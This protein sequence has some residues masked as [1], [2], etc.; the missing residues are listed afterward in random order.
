MDIV[1]VGP[2]RAGGALGIAASEAGHR[3]V[4]VAGRDPHRTEALAERLGAAPRRLDAPLGPA[5]LLVLAVRDDA[6]RPVAAAVDASGIPA[7]VHLSGARPVVDLEP[8]ADRGVAV[9]V[10]H[11]LQTLPDPET[12]AA[13]LA[14]AWA[15]IT[16]VD[17]LADVLEGLARD[18]GMRPFHLADDHRVL[19]HAGAAAAA[20]AVVA[21]LAVAARLFARAEVPFVAARPLVETVVANAFD[22]GPARALTGPVARGDV[23]TVRAQLAA[24][25]EGAPETVPAFAALVEAVAVVAG[26]SP[27]EFR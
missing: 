11:P 15:A 7:A 21:A 13:A 1:I 10:F 22:L 27:E 23:A 9:G 12:G 14:G 26:R 19:Y 16:A 4:A 6:I 5:E 25:A 17:P 18:L 3:V 8:L 20:N 24:V 2:G